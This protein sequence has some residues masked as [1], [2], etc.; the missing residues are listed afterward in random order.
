MCDASLLIVMTICIVD[1]LISEFM[2]TADKKFLFNLHH[3]TSVQGWELLDV[4]TTLSYVPPIDFMSSF[5]SSGANF[6]AVKSESDRKFQ[7]RVVSG[8]ASLDGESFL[9]VFTCVG[10][11]Q[12][13][14]TSY[15]STNYNRMWSFRV[16]KF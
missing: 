1:Q 13:G 6:Q 5:S 11:A 10:N 16:L 4:S 9:R 12:E 8:N 3:F 2:N 15:A 14:L 7:Y